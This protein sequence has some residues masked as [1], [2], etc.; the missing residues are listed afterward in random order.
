MGFVL[1]Q[2]SVKIIVKSLNRW[3]Y[4]C[5]LQCNCQIVIRSES[6]SKLGRLVKIVLCKDN[7]GLW[8]GISI[9][10]GDII[11]LP[12]ELSRYNRIRALLSALAS[13]PKT[14][15]NPESS[16]A[17]VCLRLRLHLITISGS[18]SYITLETLINWIKPP[19][20]VS[21]NIIRFGKEIRSVLH[22]AQQIYCAPLFHASLSHK[23]AF[24]RRRDGLNY[25]LLFISLFF[26]LLFCIPPIR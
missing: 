4:P 16:E 15:I 26:G 13:F 17:R 6:S 5:K 12:S 19:A 20:V 10:L 9:L 25:R 7:I 3:S 18:V 1:Y 11:A 23:A 24:T 14:D 22:N 8:P 21:L 2:G